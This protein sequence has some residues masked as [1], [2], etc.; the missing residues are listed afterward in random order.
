MATASQPSTVSGNETPAAQP[1]QPE[2]TL[3]KPTETPVRALEKIDDKAEIPAGNSAETPAAEKK[4]VRRATKLSLSSLIDEDV[5]IELS[6]EN[7]AAVPAAESSVEPGLP[8]DETIKANWQALAASYNY[9][10]R[11]A[12]ALSHSKLAFREEEGVKIVEFALVNDAQR[13]WIQSNMLRD[14]EARFC[15]IMDCG[16]IRLIPTVVPEEEQEEL[17]YM[18]SE[19]AEDL[20]SKNAEVRNLVTDLGLDIR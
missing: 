13:G 19:K 17:K 14:I 1:S 6:D 5:V 3:E 10:P 4:P 8:T 15:Q 9:L 11:L 16:K 2:A 20:M 18:P 7:K 12:N